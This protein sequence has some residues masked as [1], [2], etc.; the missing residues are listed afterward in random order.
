MTSDS[1]GTVM[2][3][4]GPVPSGELGLTSCHEHVLMN[5]AAWPQPEDELGRAFAR[6]PVTIETI[7][8][9]RRDSWSLNY[10]NYV[11]DDVDVAVDELTKFRDAGGGTIVD[12]TTRGLSPQPEKL[13]HIA[14][15]A[16]INIVAGCGHYIASM[17]EPE[18]AR[19]SVETLAAQLLN[20]IRDGIGG[21]TVR[22][23]I[24]GELGTSEVIEESEARVL[25]AAAMAHAETGLAINVHTYPW[26]RT[27]IEVAKL[28]ISEHVDPNRIV[29]SHLDNAPID[30]NYHK[31]L[32]ALGVWVEYDGF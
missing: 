24:I 25:R 32:A 2:T 31:E 27:G 28:L 22:P 19:A 12:L 18:V 13:R 6:L 20:E 21:S 23:G 16:G 14:Q 3:T 10:D 1:G 7:G 9:L 30:L 26:G 11:L 29:I 17:H 4:D 15:L 8:A 5:M